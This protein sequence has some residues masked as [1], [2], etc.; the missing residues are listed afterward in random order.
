M[1]TLDHKH[2]LVFAY[3]QK[4]PKVV[5]HLEDWFRRLVEAVNMKVLIDPKCVYCDTPGNEGITGIVCIETSHASIHFWEKHDQNPDLACLQFDLY[6]C[7]YFDPKT[8]ME[9]LNEFGL[10]DYQYT[11]VDRNADFYV[12][13][14]I[15]L[16]SDRDS[17]KKS[18]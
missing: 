7:K 17:R 4:P 6:S 2:M 11:I 18:A 13:E 3:V 15:N 9:L 12:S 5:E 16:V 1:E 8:V 10:I 14:R